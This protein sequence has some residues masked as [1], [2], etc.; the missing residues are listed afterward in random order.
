MTAGADF[1]VF[2]PTVKQNERLDEKNIRKEMTKYLSIDEVVGE[3]S[4]IVQ[5]SLCSLIASASILFNDPIDEVHSLGAS[6]ELLPI[7]VPSSQLLLSKVVIEV[8]ECS[9]RMRFNGNL[10][11]VLGSEVNSDD[12]LG[13]SESSVMTRLTP[14]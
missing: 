11:S 8:P 1:Y 6:S 2:W 9:L 5:S 10:E 12:S 3:D 4:L 7:I 14:H 13:T